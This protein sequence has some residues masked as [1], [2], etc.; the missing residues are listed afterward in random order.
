MLPFDGSVHF[1]LAT[2]LNSAGQKDEAQKEFEIHR[3]LTAARAP[4]NAGANPQ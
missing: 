4:P 1:A 3:K 2:A